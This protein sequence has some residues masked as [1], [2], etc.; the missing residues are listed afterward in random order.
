MRVRTLFFAALRTA[1]VGQAVLSDNICQSLPLAGCGGSFAYDRSTPGSVAPP[2]TKR[3]RRQS[4][5]GAVYAAQTS[6]DLEV[7]DE[8]QI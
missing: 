3:H 4:G 5:S 8:N 2:N 7:Y 1:G 6:E